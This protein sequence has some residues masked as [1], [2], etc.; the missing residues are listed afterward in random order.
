MNI[1]RGSIIR[2]AREAFGVE[3]I[4][5]NDIPRLERFATLIASER[6]KH[7]HKIIDDECEA[8][9]KEEREACAK[10]CFNGFDNADIFTLNKCGN[11]IRARG[12]A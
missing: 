11:A 6:D 2:M 10:L 8:V 3:I 4:Y 5:D 12:K 9:I 1:D 7:W